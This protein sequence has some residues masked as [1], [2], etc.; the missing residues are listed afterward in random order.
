MISFWVLA[1]ALL[2]AG[3]AF[4][5]PALLGRKSTPG[6]DRARLNWLINRQK[7]EELAAEIGDR[8]AAEQLGD[9]FDR[10]LLA[11]LAASEAPPSKP[12][13]G[14]G[15]TLLIAVLAA[16]PL[17]VIAIYGGL[18]RMDLIAHPAAV[19]GGNQAMTAGDLQA[20][21]D[22]LAERL[23]QQPNDLDGWL[24]LG[25]SLM[26]VQQMDK[27]V[28]AYEF[29]LKLAPENLDVQALYAQA[30]GEANQGSLQGKPS[31]IIDGILQRNPNHLH[32]LWLAGLAAA[33]LEDK[34]RAVGYW[35]KLKS[36]MPAG[37]EQVQEL[38]KLI[39]EMGGGPSAP[40][41]TPAASGKSIRVKVSL[42]A[43]LKERAAPD[44]VLFIFARAAEGPPMPLA[45]SRKNAGDLPTEITLDD[46]MAMAPG[47]KLS[48]YPRIVI[49]ARI[50][51]TGN[52]M[53]SPGDLQGLTAPLE[54]QNGGSYAVEIGQVV[55]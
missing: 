12:E 1:A 40:A 16:L 4:F 34:G 30:L 15:R 37:S 53:P 41:D 32:G 19:S 18:G 31:E 14:A 55:N 24:L 3:Y 29:A 9:D 44:D 38:D 52:A 28:Q 43:E 49:G 10:D 17:A 51:K 7:R 6:V 25:R 11:D 46:G 47:M 54:A 13:G 5:L 42:S 45:I 36:L 26:A 21:I 23:K 33:E 35:S 48:S 22:Q 50:S 8:N 2:L 39:A 20:R 27:A